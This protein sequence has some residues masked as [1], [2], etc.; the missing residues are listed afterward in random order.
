VVPAA[1]DHA[2]IVTML[3]YFGVGV[4]VKALVVEG[5]MAPLASPDDATP[6]SCCTTRRCCWRRSSSPAWRRRS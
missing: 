5:R 4:A 2:L 6:P 3:L 1:G